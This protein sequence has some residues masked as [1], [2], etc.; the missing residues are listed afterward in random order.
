MKNQETHSKRFSLSSFVVAFVVLLL[1]FFVTSEQFA[2]K[3]KLEREAII[4]EEALKEEAYKKELIESMS[5]SEKKANFLKMIVPP[6]DEVY[7]EELNYF[8]DIKVL[9][10]ENPDNAILE[11]LRQ[12][13]NAKDNLELLM[14]LKPHPKSITIAQAAMESAWGESRFFKEAN[15]LFGVWSY[16]K[17]EP[18]IAASSLRGEKT[19][20]LKKYPTVKE[21]I[22]DYYKMLSRSWAFKEF[23]EL[24]FE[25]KNQNPY[26]LVK[27][28]QKYS[29]KREV[30]TKEL[31]SMINYNKFTKFDEVYYER[32]KQQEP[33]KELL[34]LENDAMQE[35]VPKL[36][37]TDML[38]IEEITKKENN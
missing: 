33:K 13:Y 25:K 22:K 27:K 3:E 34:L 36:K 14:A 26:L 29:E 9:V 10:K 7:E 32:P 21:A 15:N 17:N 6:L 11:G 16:N 5:V 28:L 35:D 31:S 2:L 8:N 19:I 20:W 23:R 30:Y 1:I 18:R 24:N 4:K 37:P 12:E 38:D